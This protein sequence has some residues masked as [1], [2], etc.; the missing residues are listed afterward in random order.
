MATRQHRTP[1]V[2]QLRDATAELDR[3]RKRV[4]NHDQVCSECHA[5]GPDTAKLCEQGWRLA[6]RLARASAAV[7][8]CSDAAAADRALERLW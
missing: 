8:R 2:D 6:K 3:V 1:I 5:A 4:R 7:R